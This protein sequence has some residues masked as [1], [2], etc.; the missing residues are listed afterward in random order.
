MATILSFSG[1]V[2]LAY[3]VNCLIA[4]RQHSKQPQ[5]ALVLLRVYSLPSNGF[6]DAA[7]VFGV[8]LHSNGCLLLNYLISSQN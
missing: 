2:P 8:P 7:G 6:L 4:V 3:V 1:S 5:L